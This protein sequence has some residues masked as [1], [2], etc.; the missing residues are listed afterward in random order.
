MK[1]QATRDLFRYW[2]TIRGARASPERDAFDPAAIRHLLADTFLIERANGSFPLRLSGTRVDALWLE[3]QK[4][5]DFLDFWGEDRH[6]VAAALWTV[7]DGAAPMVLGAH[8]KLLGRPSVEVEGLLMPLRHHGKTHSLL[9]GALSLSVTPPWIGLL[10]IE[11]LELASLRVLD[12]A[13]EIDLPV[14][15][16]MP[17]TFTPKTFATKTFTPEICAPLASVERRAHLTIYAGGRLAPR[18]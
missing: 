16:S 12:A 4:G 11:H 18:A 13:Q 17:K 7:M 2:N 15:P 6:C 5:R 3:D 10:P 14:M 8:T 1:H 9:L